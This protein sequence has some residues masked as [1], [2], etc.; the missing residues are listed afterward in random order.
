MSTLRDLQLATWF[1][2]LKR[3]RLPIFVIDRRGR[4]PAFR[5]RAVESLWNHKEISARHN[6]GT[7]LAEERQH[8]CLDRMILFA[9]RKNLVPL[10]GEGLPRRTICRIENL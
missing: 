10:S 3:Y 2:I 9:T 5:V 6:F 7:K 4:G 8:C 1:N